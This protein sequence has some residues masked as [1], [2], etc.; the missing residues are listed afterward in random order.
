LFT[1]T[2][3]RA[4][5]W[6]ALVAVAAATQ[7]S[8]AE[9]AIAEARRF[10]ANNPSEAA[11]HN[12]LG[13]ALAQRA[14]ETANPAFYDQA[15]EALNKSLEL[16]PDNFE[17]RKLEVWL[18]L[19]KHEFHRALE[20]AKQLNRRAADDPMIYGFI[21]DACA[22]L[23][24]YDEAEEAAQWMLDLGRSSVPGLTRAAHLREIF[25]DSEG[26]A[27]L[28]ISAYEK[29]D[30]R[31]IEDRAWVLTHL[32]HLRLFGGQLKAAERL[33]DEA[34]RQFPGYHYA[35]FQMARLR[36]MQGRHAESVELLRARYHSAPHPENL[37][38][39]AVALQNAQRRSEARKTFRDFEEVARRESESADNANRE[40]IFYFADYAKRPKEALAVARREVARRRDVH[41]LDAVAWAYYRAGDLNGARR[42]I[43]AALKMGIR[44]ARILYHAGAIATSQ[45]DYTA[46][47]RYLSD[48]LATNAHSEVASEAK[49][50]LA[51]LP[52]TSASQR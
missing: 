48:S 19:G 45:R 20:L 28:M 1:L 35:Q 44:E 24:K 11:G 9:R 36:T 10:I 42:E 18:L 21:A 26:A 33:L 6:L 30:P 12:A 16:A 37:F 22:E 5:V 52:R 13:M 38:D 7:P 25:G 50:L 41:T 29:L 34:L 43:E 2:V 14:R 40:L 17:A 27:E 15:S 4:L 31:Q 39:L 51:R 8:P 49:R 47:A 23:G 3:S 32:A 46:A